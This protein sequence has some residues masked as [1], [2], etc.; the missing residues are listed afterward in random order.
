MS[1]AIF[2]ARTLTDPHVAVRWHEAV[3][4]VLETADEAERQQ[5]G[6]PELDDLA[7]TSTGHVRLLVE[8]PLREFSV[9]RLG[10][11]LDA[12]IHDAAMPDELRA[13]GSDALRAFATEPV[14]PW[15]QSLGFFERPDRTAQLVA[16]AERAAAGRERQLID[17]EL[18]RLRGRQ[19]PSD[20]ARRR[21]TI[22]LLRSPRVGWAMSFGFGA[23]ALGAAWSWRGE[24]QDRIQPRLDSWRVEWRNRFEPTWAKV[25]TA[26][27]SRLTALPIRQDARTPSSS[28]VEP[29]ATPKRSRA[30]V[31]A[32]GAIRRAEENPAARAV[33]PMPAPIEQPQVGRLSNLTPLAEASVASVPEQNAGDATVYS[34]ADGNVRPPVLLSRSMPSKPSEDFSGDGVFDLVVDEHGRVERV[35]LI[36]PGNLYQERMLVA[37]AKAWRFQP[38]SLDGVPVRYRTQVQITW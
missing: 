10:Q 23:A 38:A 11:L 8:S 3:A 7:L 29:T 28:P 12:L 27:S 25:S 4:L 16:L 33:L 26:V 36:S 32:T 14:A 20:P 24:L 1:E 13:F 22:Q 19:R 17:D 21:R 6:V 2:S 31:S 35:E 9:P 34:A 15:L 37:V 30:T 18:R 5:T